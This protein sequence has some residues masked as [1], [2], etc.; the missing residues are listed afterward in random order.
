M[1]N[2][3]LEKDMIEKSVLIMKGV[4][5]L[6]E[7]NRILGIEDSTSKKWLELA[8]EN[9]EPYKS[10]AEELKLF[11]EKNG[12]NYDSIVENDFKIFKDNELDFLLEDNYL[13]SLENTREDKISILKTRVHPENLR[14]SIENLKKETSK[15]DDVFNLLMQLDESALIG[16]L[17]DGNFE[18][19]S[20]EEIADK[21]I[22]DLHIKNID[23]LIMNLESYL[24]D[25]NE[26]NITS[27][28]SENNVLKSVDGDNV[29]EV[30]SED[31]VLEADDNNA[32][33]DDLG[34]D[35]LNEGNFESFVDGMMNDFLNALKE[36]KSEEE[37]MDI[38]GVNS[39]TLMSWKIMAESGD[40][41]FKKFH[42]E[43]M[44][45]M[46]NN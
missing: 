30:V 19:K 8:E 40:E 20:K 31:N 35:S 6:Q 3:D 41:T 39:I 18:S 27:Q 46:K 5:S 10:Y 14:D 13:F 7:I 9:I 16:L 23:K 25:L 45:L 34:N 11:L 4:T 38:S 15:L 29:L 2:N 42:D 12:L 22:S 28:L 44:N 24:S 33:E 36:G 43:Y 17:D 26:F 1:Q 32:I 37:A 21:I